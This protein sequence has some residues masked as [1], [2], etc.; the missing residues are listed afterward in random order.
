MRAAP[1][2]LLGQAAPTAPNQVWVGDSTYLPQQDGGWL[3]LATWFDRYSRKVVGWDVRETM[4]EYLVS[5][6][7]RRA[8]AVRQPAAGLV[9]HSDQGSQYSATNFKD[10]VARHEARQSMSRRGNCQDNAHAESLLEPTQ[11]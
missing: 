7:L 2:R 9:V 3:Y 4:P 1:N 6:A 11:N 8:L 10:V 5:E